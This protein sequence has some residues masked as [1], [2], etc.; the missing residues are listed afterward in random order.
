MY[1]SY[2]VAFPSDHSPLTRTDRNWVVMQVLIAAAIVLAVI[3]LEPPEERFLPVSVGVTLIAISLASFI[4]SFVAHVMVNHTLQV[5]VSPAPD[6]RKQLVV[7]GIYAYIRHPMYL[8]AVL[9]I[10]GVAI[11]HGNIVVIGG[12]LVTTL[13]VHLKAIHE[14]QLLQ[15]VYADYPVY[16]KRTG[17]LLPRLWR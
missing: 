1:I 3:I 5:N 12:G 16:M 7:R 4:A 17:R 2:D 8:S 6:S 10:F 15:Q 14:E 11:C 9:L 13:F